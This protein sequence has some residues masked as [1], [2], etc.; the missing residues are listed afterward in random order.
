ME[1]QVWGCESLDR[2]A[3]R[4]LRRRKPLGVPSRWGALRRINSAAVVSAAWACQLFIVQPRI[5]SKFWQIYRTSYPAYFLFSSPHCA[6]EVSLATRSLERQDFT[7]NF[8]S[9]RQ[10]SPQTSPSPL[11][12]ATDFL[13]TLHCWS[14]LCSALP[15][16]GGRCWYNLPCRCLLQCIRARSTL[17][18]WTPKREVHNNGDYRKRNPLPGQRRR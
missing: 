4:R 13:D 1:K 16:S 14:S 18:G 6:L 15:D 2:S 3:S 5:L 9:I 10:I 17:R 12:T 7:R 8:W 11:L